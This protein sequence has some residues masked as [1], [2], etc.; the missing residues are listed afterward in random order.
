M[1]MRP[2]FSR[3]AARHNSLSPLG[4]LSPAELVDS[5]AAL[6]VDLAAAAAGDLHARSGEG[7]RAAPVCCER[8]AVYKRHDARAVFCERDVCGED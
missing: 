1:R 5:G 6:P 2:S 3:P 7:G 8:A 4:G